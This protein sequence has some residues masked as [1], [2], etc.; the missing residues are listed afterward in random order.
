MGCSSLIGARQSRAPHDLEQYWNQHGDYMQDGH[1]ID[2][3]IPNPNRTTH[4]SSLK[5]VSRAQM[6]QESWRAL[7]A[8]SAK[9][10]ARDNTTLTAQ[11]RRAVDSIEGIKPTV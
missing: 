6:G 3:M 7:W 5:Q 2:Q 9:R 1:I 10:A 8:Y 4:E 11:Q